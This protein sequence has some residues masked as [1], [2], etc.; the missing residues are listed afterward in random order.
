MTSDTPTTVAL[1]CPACSR[2]TQIAPDRTDPPNTA[3]VSILCDRCDD[4]GGWP[5]ANYFDAQGRQIDL[6]GRP[7]S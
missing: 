4:G 3:R 2:V 7:M 1:T 6:E 5:E